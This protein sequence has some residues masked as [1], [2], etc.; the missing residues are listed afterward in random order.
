MEGRAGIEQD[1]RKR[2][3]ES[4]AGGKIEWMEGRAG[5]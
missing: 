1:E 2:K 4:G 5:R 3:V